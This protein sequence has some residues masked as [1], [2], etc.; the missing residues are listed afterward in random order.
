[1]LFTGMWTVE[2]D[3]STSFDLMLPDFLKSVFQER[4]VGGLTQLDHVADNTHDQETHSDGLR[5]AEE[6]ALVGWRVDVS[7]L[8][9]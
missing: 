7:F 5:D 1:M 9:L 4:L 8:D 2:N 6:L 3:V